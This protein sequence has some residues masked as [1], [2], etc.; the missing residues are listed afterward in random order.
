[1]ATTARLDLWI[2]RN[3]D[4]Y[5]FP[6]RVIGPD[7]RG[8][9]LKMEARLIGDTPGPASIALATVTNG[10]AEGIRL[11]DTTFDDRGNAINDVRIRLNK[12]TRQD[13]VKV[14]YMGELGD[15]ASLSYALLIGG[16]TRLVGRIYAPA[17]AYGSD[18]APVSRPI[19][20]GQAGQGGS[21]AISATLEISQNGGA[22]ISVGGL[23][24]IDEVS[25]R[26][27]AQRDDQRARM[28]ARS[29]LYGISDSATALLFAA[30]ATEVAFADNYYRIGYNTA[31][32]L[33]A[34]PGV[35]IYDGPVQ[36]DGRGLLV[37]GTTVVAKGQSITG[38]FTFIIEADIPAH[39]GQSRDIGYYVG[40]VLES[41]VGVFRSVSGVYALQ[42]YHPSI[43]LQTVGDL[44]DLTA[45][46]IRVAVTVGATQTRVSFAGRPALGISITRPPSL[47]R[48]W[49]GR[50]AV[51]QGSPLNGRVLRAAIYPY[52]VTDDQ[53]RAMSGGPVNNDEVTALINQKIQVHDQ[54]T[55]A[56][57]LSALRLKSDLADSK[58]G[59]WTI[60]SAD[61]FSAADG[62][63][64]TAPT[65]GQAW[66]GNGGPQ[67]IRTSGQARAP[68]GNLCGNTLNAG[69]S[70]GQVEADLIPGN[71]E[72]SLYIR[73]QSNGNYLFLQRKPDTFIGL[74][75]FL[76]GVPT[77]I[78][79]AKYRG[80]IAGERY[81]V[82][83]IGPRVWVFRVVAG[84]EELLFDVSE[85]NFTTATSHGLRLNGT[86]AA[87]N[88]RVLK[89]EA[90]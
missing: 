2:W 56:H 53:L 13:P 75:R 48:F 42:V 60:A 63:F 15:T 89:R 19:G 40:N 90:L 67:L 1:M 71:N 32:D 8:V 78:T 72:S 70:N 29:G 10:N 58:T 6:L 45:R 21:P 26:L 17:H 34:F 59:I 77:L 3:D 30:E 33:A 46:R 20:Y 49:F 84:E 54:D 14:P 18:N 50:T 38:D 61:D 52:P 80:V 23:D 37:S 85:P 57:E 4:V 69:V 65:G 68:G 16:V 43:G 87:D 7:L 73:F 74:S 11:A 55:E 76:A 83:F 22:A 39:D 31:P 62:A 28:E 79:P 47:L 64:T 81:K 51:G 24:V 66:N 27:L 88:F 12:S 36:I 86:G 44:E 9:E 5:E 41:R 82:R 25:A 35:E